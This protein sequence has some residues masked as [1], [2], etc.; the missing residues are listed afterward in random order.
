VIPLDGDDADL[1]NGCETI[2]Y[3]INGAP[4]G[5][6]VNGD[7]IEWTPTGDQVC[8]HIISVTVTDLCSAE[9]TTDDFEICVTNEPPYFVDCPVDTFEIAWGQEFTTTLVAED[10]DGGPYKLYS[11]SSFDGPGSPTVTKVAGN[12]EVSWQTDYTPD[13]TG[14]FNMC[15]TVTD[16]AATC[17]PC[18]PDNSDECCFVIHVVPFQLTI[19]KVEDALLGQNYQV[20][21]TMLD[22]TYVNAPLAGFDF[23]IQ[24]DASA[25]SFVSAEEG[26]FLVDCE[27]EYFTYRFGPNGNCGP[28]ACP[29]GVLRV[30]AIAETT[31]GNLAHHPK[32]L[33]NGPGVS[34]ELVKLNFLLSSNALYE[35]QFAPI[36]WIWYDCADNSV[37]STFGDTLY[38]SEK[39]YDFAGFDMTD[40]G[41][42]VPIYNEVTGMDNDFPTMTGAPSPECDVATEKGHPWR[43]IHFYNG[44]IDIIC[45][46]SIDAVGDINLNNV[47]YEVADAVMFTMYFING[48]T[49]FGDHFDGSVAAS[50]TN[51][52]GLTLTVA[53]LVYLIRVVVGDAQPYPKSTP[54][55]AR[56]LVNDGVYSID[57]E[58]GA[59]YMV[60]EG[61]QTPRLLASNM[62]MVSGVRDGNTHVLVYN[63]GEESFSGAF[64]ESD[65]RLI[66]S[67][68]ATYEGLQMTAKLMPTSFVVEQ[69]Y[70]NPFNPT[71]TV[72]FQ[73]PNG[74]AWS[75]DI[76]NI[77][78]QRVDSFQG[79]SDDGFVEFEWDA[80]ELASGIY[81]YKVTAGQN[82]ATM[83]A[84]LL[85]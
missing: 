37:S 32:C 10:P 82:T 55:A 75:V 53:D 38:I 71:T 42:P 16:D 52:D 48:P 24:Y 60:F 7:Q 28:N 19:E 84:V 15:V 5:M 23:L 41:N 62:D 8:T 72:A 58:T 57:H 22:D 63:I 34:N 2:S 29:S 4:D 36:R 44:G 49:A 79:V 67:E 50:D 25:M 6:T 13:F 11:I 33:T 61:T 27:W 45:A 59:A 39:V 18:S 70:P 85:K 20:G 77:T 51:K 46:D 73:V 68:F 78:G 3:S 65:G 9:A 17:D 76:Y 1:A 40:P 66:S 21:V 83:K 43:L 64:L 30:V 56:L 80:S 74:G 14:Y 12:G 26:D 47:P 69:N 31:G 54:V 35:C 81:F